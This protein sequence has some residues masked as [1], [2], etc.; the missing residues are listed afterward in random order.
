MSST[1]NQSGFFVG[2]NP[3]RTTTLPA[4][5]NWKSRPVLKKGR[6]TKRCLA[7][8]EV[9]REV[10]G[11]SPVEKRMLEMIRTGVAS[12]EK[13]AVKHCRARFGTHR[14]AQLKRDELVRIVQQSRKK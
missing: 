1:N 7:V 11:F 12:K 2:L 3:G 8:R 13:K 5:Q 9:I 6:I 4:K 10:A 14:R